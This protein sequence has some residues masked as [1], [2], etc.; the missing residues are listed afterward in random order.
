MKDVPLVIPD[1]DE[2]VPVEGGRGALA[3]LVAHLLVAEVLLPDGRSVHVVGI[4]PERLEEREHVL[5]VGGGRARG[6]R[7]VVGVRRLVRRASRA[8]RSHAIFPVARS[9]AYTT[10]R[11]V[12]LGVMP[13]RGV[14]VPAPDADAGMAV[15]T[16]TRS[17][18]TTGD[19]DPRPGISTFQRTFFVSLHSSGGVA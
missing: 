10:K 5:P 12:S 17:P 1:H 16:N 4:E 13:P 9:K 11:C 19:D 14:C 2:V 6:P 15:R 8:M 7:A 18:Q 3:E